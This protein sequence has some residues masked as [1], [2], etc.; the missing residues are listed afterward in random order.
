M[1]VSNTG[2]IQLLSAT[3]VPAGQQKLVRAKVSDWLSKGLALFAPT[4]ENLDLSKADA[5]VQTDEDGY[6]NLIIKN[7]GYW[8]CS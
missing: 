1:Q 6:L 7:T 8:P 5:V 2:V 4:I 3:R